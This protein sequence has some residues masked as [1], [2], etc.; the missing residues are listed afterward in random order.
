MISGAWRIMHTYHGWKREVAR[1]IKL[2][3]GISSARTF[4]PRIDDIITIS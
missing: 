1:V 3:G 2:V 4:D